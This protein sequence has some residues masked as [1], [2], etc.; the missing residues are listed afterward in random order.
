MLTFRLSAKAVALIL[1]LR[2]CCYFQKILMHNI[3]VVTSDVLYLAV[4][5]P[6]TRAQHPGKLEGCQFSVTHR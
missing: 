5:R 1:R 2:H 6:N 4:G 3:R